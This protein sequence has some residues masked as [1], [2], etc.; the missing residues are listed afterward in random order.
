VEADEEDQALH[1][2]NPLGVV[3]SSIHPQARPRALM[4]VSLLVSARRHTTRGGGGVAR[5]D[6]SVQVQ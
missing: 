6:R 1:T 4:T 3:G 5:T 2:E